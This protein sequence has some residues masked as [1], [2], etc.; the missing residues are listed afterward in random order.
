MYQGLYLLSTRQFKLASQQLLDGLAT[1]T[2]VE[3]MEYKD[4][5]K[6]TVLSSVLVLERI[7][8]KTK[9]LQSPEV[10]ECV[11]Q[12]PHLEDLMQSLYQCQYSKFFVALAA[13][14]QLYFKTDRYL[15]QQSQWYVR[16]MRIKAYQQILQSYRSL[17]LQSMSQA[18]GVSVTFIDQELSHFIAQGRLQCVIDKVSGVVETSRQDDKNAKYLQAIKQGDVLLNHIQKLARVI[19][20]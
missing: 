16:E 15:H 2:S 11:H 19:N 3:L 13:L 18:F 10:L 20:I 1:F 4:L 8:L 12:V 6:Y 9:V 14:E 5:V 7:D 17:T